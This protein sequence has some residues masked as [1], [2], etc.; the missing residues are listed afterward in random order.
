MT[1]ESKVKV[2]YTENSLWL[3]TPAPFIFLWRVFIFGIMNSFG[4]KIVT[5]EDFG[6]QI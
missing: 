6:S 1:L 3:V 2:Q 5:L 4:V